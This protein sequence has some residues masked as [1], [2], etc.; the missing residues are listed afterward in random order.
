MEISTIHL[1]HW[2][3][4]YLKMMLVHTVCQTHLWFDTADTST[5]G[6]A[7]WHVII[8]CTSRGSQELAQCQDSQV[9]VIPK[10]YLFLLGFNIYC[11]DTLVFCTYF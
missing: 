11:A 4:V 7:V 2:N 1:L 6:C 8:V 3:V 9:K 10:I 5:V